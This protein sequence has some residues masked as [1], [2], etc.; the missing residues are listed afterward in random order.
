MRIEKCVTTKS[1]QSNHPQKHK[2]KSHNHK[3]THKPT[4]HTTPI[5]PGHKQNQPTTTPKSPPTP[6]PPSK[7]IETQT[8]PNLFNGNGVGR[9][10]RQEVGVQRGGLLDLRREEETHGPEEL[11]LLTADRH[12][13]EEPVH[14]VHGQGEHLLLS[15]FL[16]AHLC[17]MEGRGRGGG[18]GVGCG[19]G[20]GWVG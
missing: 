8:Y 16:L 2:Q 12:Q 13:R 3:R 6:L 14:H 15:P 20:G 19:I 11:Q 10:L 5:H 17:S 18:D 1:H 9:V 4:N 7:K